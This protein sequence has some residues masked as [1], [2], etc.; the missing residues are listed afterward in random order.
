LE[1]CR[2]APVRSPPTSG[3][4]EPGTGYTNG[5]RGVELQGASSGTT[6]PGYDLAGSDGGVFVFRPGSPQLLRVLPGLGVK[7]NN[8]VAS[9]PPTTSPVTTS[10]D[11]M[12]GS[13]CSRPA[14]PRVSRIAPGL[15]VNVNNVVGIV[16]TNNFTGYDLGGIRWWGFR[17]PDRPVLGILRIAAQYGVQVND[18]VGI[19]ASPG[20]GGYFLVGKDGGV[21]TFG[22]ASFFGSLPGTGVH[23]TNINRNASTTDGQGYYVVGAD[24][25]RL[26]LRRRHVARLTPGPGRQCF[27]HREHRAHPRR[28]GLLA[29]RL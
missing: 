19:V 21:F 27:E 26:R 11:P 2:R 10:W 25:G 22:S 5:K 17:V 24:G 14:S 15:G 4:A 13:S 12:V 8:I 18:I 6:T 1:R 20:G 7:V 9:C 28:R 23:V 16:P 29:H 3:P